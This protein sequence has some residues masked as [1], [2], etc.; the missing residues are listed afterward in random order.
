MVEVNDARFGKQPSELDGILR[1]LGRVQ[2]ELGGTQVVAAVAGQLGQ[3][4]KCRGIAGIAIHALGVNLVRGGR[5]VGKE[6]TRRGQRR[7][8]V[9]EL[10]DENGGVFETSRARLCRRFLGSSA[11]E[12][13]R[14]R[15][16]LFT[17]TIELFDFVQ[18]FGV[19]RVLRQSALVKGAERLPLLALLI[20]RFQLFVGRVVVGI[21]R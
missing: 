21:A 13:I 5:V 18:D 11:F 10:V 9:L 2:V 14:K 3:S 15:P 12:Q 6:G 8:R 4:S 17:A 20:N 7:A 16:P 19:V 1:A